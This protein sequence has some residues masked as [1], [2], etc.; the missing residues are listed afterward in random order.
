[1]VTSLTSAADA[2]SRVLT[3]LYPNWANRDAEVVRIRSSVLPFDEPDVPVICIPAACPRHQIFLSLSARQLQD[4]LSQVGCAP[5]RTPRV[6]IQLANQ[7]VRT[8]RPDKLFVRAEAV[9]MLQIGRA[10]CR[11]R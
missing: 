7:R 10:S 8:V 1:I 2:I 4:R 5:I 3:P 6:A 11:E 9:A